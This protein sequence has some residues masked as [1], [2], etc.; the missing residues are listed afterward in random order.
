[1]FIIKRGMHCAIVISR[2]GFFFFFFFHL[3]TNFRMRATPS[4][5]I[6]K[7][8]VDKRTERNGKFTGRI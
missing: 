7:L 6:F 3:K 2:I 4:W 5:D 1:M 8:V